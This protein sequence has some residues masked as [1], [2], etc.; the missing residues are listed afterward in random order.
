MPR[1]MV[2]AERPGVPESRLVLEERMVAADL[3]SAGASAQLVERVGWAID[4]EQLE[5]AEGDRRERAAPHRGRP[6]ARA[7]GGRASRRC[8]IEA[9]RRSMHAR[10][11]SETHVSEMLRDGATL[12]EMETFIDRQPISE[13]HRSVLWLQAWAEQTDDPARRSVAR[14][15]PIFIAGD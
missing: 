2:L 5:Q 6:S 4:A 15:R 13:E 10:R 11:S 3:D 12:A 14:V 7:H 1:M 9:R 8:A